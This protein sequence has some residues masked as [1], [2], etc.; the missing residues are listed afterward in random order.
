MGLFFKQKLSHVLPKIGHAKKNYCSWNHSFF[1]QMQHA[2]KSKCAD[3]FVLPIVVMR[4]VVQFAA[5]SLVDVLA[6]RTVSKSFKKSMQSPMMF[7]HIL[8]NLTKVWSRSGWLGDYARGLHCVKA[9]HVA[10]LEPLYSM[11]SVRHL[12]LGGGTFDS[13]TL[14]NALC[15]L[16]FLE[17]LDVSGCASVSTLT[18]SL[19]NLKELNVSSCRNL[20]TLPEF[21]NLVQ[22]RANF[23]AKL[24]ILPFLPAIENLEMLHCPAPID[25]ESV[26]L[27]TTHYKCQV[28]FYPCLKMLT[29]YTC[30]AFHI[31]FLQPLTAL[32]SLV[33]TFK[34]NMPNLNLLALG[35]L[36]QLTTLELQN[37]ITDDHVRVI[38]TLAKLEALYLGSSELTDD[39]LGALTKLTTLSIDNE[40]CEG[41]TTHGLKKLT[42]LQE[43]H[44]KNCVGVDDLSNFEDLTRLNTLC[45]SSCSELHNVDAL[46]GLKSLR[47]LEF[48]S[49]SSLESFAGLNASPQ[50]ESL[51]VLCCRNLTKK[52][53][54]AL[55]PFKSLKRLTVCD[56]TPA[57]EVQI[58]GTHNIKVEFA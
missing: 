22:L 55:L 27:L 33:I 43:L 6:L 56:H 42:N 34:P 2:K 29:L 31:D 1:L 21:P 48:D 46:S 45:F 20:H 38:S 51:S 53:M 5:P 13:Q 28:G 14:N 54:M 30:D 39:C 37:N 35:S 4:I 11:P 41:V 15:T 44:L 18:Q 24:K 19:P 3:V 7:S 36:Q 52:G 23:C 9:K 47:V 50:L 17:S 26:T 40:D 16:P 25:C 8:A 49:C 32:T 57:E 10:N 58:F 12:V